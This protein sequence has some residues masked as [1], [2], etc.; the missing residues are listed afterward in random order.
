M[1]TEFGEQGLEA[2]EGEGVAGIVGELSWEKPLMFV[3]LLFRCF[4]E[5]KEDLNCQFYFINLFSVFI[6]VKKRV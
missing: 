6:I 4:G 3:G 5:E 2:S 1:P